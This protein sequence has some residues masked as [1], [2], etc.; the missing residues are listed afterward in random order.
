MYMNLL[1]QEV[2]LTLIAVANLSIGLFILSKNRASIMHRAFAVATTGI[3]IWGIDL[4]FIA[5]THALV[6]NTLTIY[7]FSL[8][9]FGFVLF[10]RVFPLQRRPKKSFYLLFIPLGLV[11]IAAP[12]NLI[13]KGII[14]HPGSYPEA[15]NGPLFSSFASLII[16][17]VC[18]GLVFFI[19]T[20]RKSSGTPR[21]QL[22]YLLLGLS[23]FLS[24]TLIFDMF[25]P[26][27]GIFQFTFLGPI[28][29]IILSACT[30]YAII[31]HQ[32][33]DIR[34]VIQRGFFFTFFFIVIIG[35]YIA[36]L[37]LAGY[38]LGEFTKMTATAMAGTIML[39]GMIIGAPFREYFKQKTDHI[40]FKG[41]YDYADALHRLS[42]KLKTNVSTAAIIQAVRPELEKIFRASSVSFSTPE[43]AVL[44]EPYIEQKSVTVPIVFE[45]TV[46]NVLT[47]GPKRSG[48]TYTQRDMQ[49]LETFA[50]QAAVAL[51]KGRLFEEVERYSSQLE[52]LVETRTKEIKKLQEDQKQAMIDISHNLQTPL[53]VMR[54]QLELLSNKMPDEDAF[55]LVEKSLNR[56]SSFI[57][58][59][60]H[61]AKLDHGAYEI[62]LTRINL[63]KL[64]RE[65]VE[66]FE[67][68]AEEK[69]VSLT[70]SISRGVCILGNKG[71]LGELLTNI[72]ANAI[73]C[74]RENSK[75]SIKIHLAKTKQAAVIT[76]YDNGVGI[77]AEELPEIFSRFYRTGGSRSLHG[78]GLG[79]AIV[80]RI[81][82][83]HSGAISVKSK[84]GD[85]TEFTI[86]IP[87]ALK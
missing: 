47:L 33:M 64:L 30:A 67:V 37:Q 55:Y 74:R 60:L 23:V 43:A 49:L 3:F 16:I 51:E 80:K 46:I 34:F 65:Q 35:L 58:Q 14:D 39:I 5:E 66:Y 22:Q 1:V 75:H 7:G 63:S 24:I 9:L 68:M 56:V 25:L 6:F 86:T 85:H 70:A 69:G 38:F 32:L 27:V 84:K 59:L 41:D 53:A 62:E 45:D 82:D 61:L 8:F 17:Y 13:I 12:L 40:F 87:L 83:R 26:S 77:E 57:R 42:T 50:S 71:L 28:A 29:S 4:V 72:V 81:V 76:I 44:L 73:E 54:N 18:L 19:R 21:I 11:L 48:D 2:V 78:T 31:R 20:Y 79:L 52:G 10:A 36:S 15:V